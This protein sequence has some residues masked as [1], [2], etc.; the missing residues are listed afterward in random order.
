[1][2]ILVLDFSSRHLVC[3][4]CNGEDI[5]R[6]GVFCDLSSCDELPNRLHQLVKDIPINRI[7]LGHGPGSYTGIRVS[8]TIAQSFG[9]CKQIPIFTVCS[10]K[11]LLPRNLSAQ[12]YLLIAMTG[13]SRY[14]GKSPFKLQTVNIGICLQ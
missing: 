14:H 13:R 2:S 6:G 9:Y 7:V 11:G 8:A 12:D 1:M 4:V 10:L 3:A 5:T